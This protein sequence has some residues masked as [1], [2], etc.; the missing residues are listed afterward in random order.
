MNNRQS[1]REQATTKSSSQVMSPTRAFP[2]CQRGK[3]PPILLMTMWKVMM[4]EKVRKKREKRAR[5]RVMRE[6]RTK[7]TW[8]KMTETRVRVTGE[9]LME[10]IQEALRMA[11]LVHLFS[12]RCGPSMTSSQR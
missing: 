11:T 10:E 8:E 12:P 4:E 9:P 3:R 6:E 1:V 2:S 7:S 5:M